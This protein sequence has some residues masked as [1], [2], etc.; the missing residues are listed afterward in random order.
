[1]RVSPSYR[2]LH[3]P[4]RWMSAWQSTVC[5][6]SLLLISRRCCVRIWFLCWITR[7]RTFERRWFWFFTRYFW[8][9]RTV[10]GWVS[11]AWRTSWRIQIHVRIYC[12]LTIQEMVLCALLNLIA[13]AAVV[14]AAVNVICELARKNPKNY[15]SL[16][17][18][19]YK[20]LTTSSNNW[21][22]IKII[23]L[24]SQCLG[25]TFC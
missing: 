8:S 21:M 14:S 9:S 2:I 4:L 17:P 22:L 23:K 18:Q 12:C 10:W 6:T 1:M 13:V 20:L 15:L 5:H 24:V 7:N 19:L 16:A 3:R 11:R 25:Y